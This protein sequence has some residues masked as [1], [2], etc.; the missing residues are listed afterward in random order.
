MVESDHKNISLIL[1]SNAFF[2]VKHR[3]DKRRAP[4]S[5]SRG[6]EMELTGATRD[7]EQ[8]NLILME[9]CLSTERRY[10]HAPYAFRSRRQIH[11]FEYLHNWIK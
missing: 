8:I 4:Q 7:F 11:V 5:S 9:P 1:I 10:R 2:R 3:R 6:R